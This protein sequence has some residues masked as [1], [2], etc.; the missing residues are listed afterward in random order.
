MTTITLELP[1]ELA[2]QYR[3]DPALLP[4]LVRETLASKFAKFTPSPAP[5]VIPLYQELV[6]FLSAKPNPK[7]T[8]AFKISPAGQDR[9]ED[10]LYR[11]REEELTQAE[12]TELETYLQL[13][14]VVTRLK[15]RA[16][17]SQTPPPKAVA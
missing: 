14:H 13:S 9:L 4:A 7:E 6:E 10:L 12:R 15:A 8:L 11:N 3:L 5:I 17:R 16:R 1:D 2:A